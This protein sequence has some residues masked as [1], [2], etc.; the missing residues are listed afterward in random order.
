MKNTMTL[1]AMLLTLALLNSGCASFSNYMGNRAYD[2][3]DVVTLTIDEGFGAKGRIGPVVVGHAVFG[4]S[5]GLRGGTF[6]L[7][8]TDWQYP[9]P[10]PYTDAN[11]RPEMYGAYDFSIFCIQNFGSMYMQTDERKKSYRA[12]VQLSKELGLFLLQF[13]HEGSSPA[14]YTDIELVAG[15]PFLGIRFGFNPGELLDFLL[16]WTTLDIYGDDIGIQE[17]EEKQSAS[18]DAKPPKEQQ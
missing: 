1:S 8:E 18:D 15:G 13:P 7:I 4:G 6:Q 17:V 12:G 11:D 9:L 2:A 3:G 10:L 16:G 14:Y 5:V